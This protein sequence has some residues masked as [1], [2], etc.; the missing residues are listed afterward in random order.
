VLGRD[1][2]V[3]DNCHLWPNVVINYNCRI[4]N[5]VIIHA[6]STIGTDGFGYRLRDGRYR[7][8]AH[9][10]TVVIEDDVEI[11][12]NS[13]VDRAKIGQ[14]VIGRGTKIDNLVMIAHNVKVGQNCIIVS[15]TGI[16]GSS[17][18]GNYVVL[19]G[20]SG[21]CDHV[22]IG[23]QVMLAAKSGI[24]TGARIEAKA[25]LAGMPAQDFVKFYR[26]LSLI[27]KLPEMAKELKRITKQLNES[28]TT[29]DNS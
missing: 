6:N 18:L 21:V 14:T 16:A 4:G 23:D 19:A 25:R 26:E 22:K 11:G 2:E 12:A 17:E 9:I 13:C 8:V 20:Q 7:K 1:V 24:S 29:K 15:Q 10:G 27:H 3:G 28:T 5:N